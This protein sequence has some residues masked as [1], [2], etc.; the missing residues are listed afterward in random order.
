V[1]SGIYTQEG[2][3]HQ[4]KP[5][6][7]NT[8]QIVERFVGRAAVRRTS[9]VEEEECALNAEFRA[10][11]LRYVHSLGVPVGEGEDIAQEVFLQLFRHLSEGKP[12]DNL[13]GWIFRVG[14]NQALKWRQRNERASG[15]ADGMQLTDPA[16]N[17]E[18]QLAAQGRRQ[19]LLAVVQALPERDRSCLFLRAE[20]LRYREIAAALDMSLGAVA[21]SLSRSLGKLTS[22]DQR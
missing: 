6:T 20:G 8:W 21:L 16:P 7:E 13:R 15:D 3:R 12:R 18:E 11:L 22:M 19:R 14:H 2:L 9:A 1:R 4:I 17:P 10:P 5:V